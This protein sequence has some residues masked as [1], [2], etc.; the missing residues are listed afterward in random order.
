MPV[1]QTLGGPQRR[2]FRCVVV[3][4]TRE[5]ALQIQRQCLLLGEGLDLRCHVIDNVAKAAQKFGPKSS[6]KFGTER[7]RCRGFFQRR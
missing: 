5:L 6:L 2:G 4:P 7:G 3:A 1:L